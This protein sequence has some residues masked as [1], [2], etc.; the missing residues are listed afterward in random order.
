MH[1]REPFIVD[2]H[3]KPDKGN[4]KPRKKGTEQVE[5]ISAPVR[6]RKGKHKAFEDDP[7]EFFDDMYDDL[8]DSCLATP[9]SDTLASRS[10]SAPPVT[11]VLSSSSVSMID[12]R[13]AK[14]EESLYQEMLIL[15]REV[16]PHT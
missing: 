1:R 15:R 7:I 14:T 11:A 16:C 6:S 2:W 5:S 9:S 13:V 12:S 10:L 3:R 4:N 8:D